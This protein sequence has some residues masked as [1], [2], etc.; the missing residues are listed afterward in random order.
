MKYIKPDGLHAVAIAA[1]CLI[2]QIPFAGATTYYVS[3]SQGSDTNSGTNTTAPW[4]S[5]T[6]VYRLQGTAIHPGDSL[7]LKAG[8]TFDGPLYISPFHPGTTEAPVTVDRYGTGANPTIYGDHPSATWSP[9]NGF[10]GIYSTPPL[11]QAGL[12]NVIKVYDIYGR[13]FSRIARG[14]NNLN[15]WLGTFTN[16]CW[17]A[18]S[19]ET[20]IYLRTTND[21]APPKMRL[22]DFFTVNVPEH[23]IVQNLEACYSG[24]GIQAGDGSIIR[25][26][27]VHDTF[28]TG[29]GLYGAS[30]CEVANNRVERSGYTQIY[31]LQGG[32][33]WVH[34]NTCTQVGLDEGGTGTYIITNC[35]IPL[36][37]S[38]NIGIQQNTNSL[39]EWN[40]CSYSRSDFIDWWLAV[41]CEARYNYGFHSGMA[42]APDGTGLKIHHNIFNMDDAGSGFNIIHDYDPIHSIAPDS[43]PIIVYNNVI[44]NHRANAFYTVGVGA[45]NVIIRNNLIFTK[46]SYVLVYGASLGSGTDCD[47][48]IFYSTGTAMRWNWNSLGQTS[49]PAWS[50][51]SGQDAH[52]IYA[53]P[54]FVSTNPITAA[55]FKLRTI[56]PCIDAGQDLKL[57]GLLSA[58]QEYK[59]YLGTLIPQGAGPDIGAYEKNTNSLAPP[60]DLH[61]EKP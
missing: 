24:H 41:D 26:N 34:H 49:L 28:S 61:L 31:L 50:A 25:S 57:A 46:S 51:A 45:T 17:G 15:T 37:E 43:G 21:A 42:T 55:D 47:Y 36:G 30:S 10:A 35:F 11:G 48:N 9:V 40:N 14:T 39:I 29:I 8:D 59:D 44:Y 22:M 3:T 2:A 33:H 19:D 18:T 7:L 20:T 52:S 16:G 6:N 4:R 5:L 1:F 32:G 53:N 60:T 58:A 38:A 27:Y 13:K 54:Q 12:I 23:Y 56:S